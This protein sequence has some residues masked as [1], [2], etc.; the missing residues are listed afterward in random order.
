MNQELDSVYSI[1]RANILQRIVSNSRRSFAVLKLCKRRSAVAPSL[2]MEAQRL[3]K[4]NI[5]TVKIL[6]KSFGPVS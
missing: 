2:L 5:A 4:D 6:E 3:L 1:I